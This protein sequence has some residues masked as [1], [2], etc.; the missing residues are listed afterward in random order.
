MD[1]T[2]AVQAEA[3]VIE[4]VL[5]RAPQHQFVIERDATQE[6]PF[7]W[8]IFYAPSAYLQSRNPRD[9]VP[10]VAPVVVTRKGRVVPL[11]SARP[12]N[13]AIEQFEKTWDPASER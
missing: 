5:N 6:R 4:Q 7:G 11:S 12:P 3:L 8:V 1:I 9:L 2:T 13:V 10:G